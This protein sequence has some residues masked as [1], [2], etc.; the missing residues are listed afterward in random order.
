MER[1]NIVTIK[2]LIFLSLQSDINL[3]AV[4]IVMLAWNGDDRQWLF[5]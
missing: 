1:V 4:E 5:T 2:I 3:Y